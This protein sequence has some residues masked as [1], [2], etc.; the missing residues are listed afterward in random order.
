[1][2]TNASTMILSKLTARPLQ[3]PNVLVLMSIKY[4]TSS[5]TSTTIRTFSINNNGHSIKQNAFIRKEQF[6]SKKGLLVA[7]EH[8]GP[9]SFSIRTFRP[10]N[11]YYEARRKTSAVVMDGLA[12]LVALTTLICTS[13]HVNYIWS[14]LPQIVRSPFE[15]AADLFVR[16]FKSADSYNKDEVDRRESNRVVDDCILKSSMVGNAN[17][18]VTIF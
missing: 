11:S 16:L 1:M 13:F 4:R 14:L 18:V 15:K 17:T 10:P 12:T 3:H 7:C 6:M 9:I 5:A 2:I 8:L